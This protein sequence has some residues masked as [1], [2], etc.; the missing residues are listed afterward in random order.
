MSSDRDDQ[1]RALGAFIRLQ[2]NLA[3]LSLRQMADLAEVSN[4]YLSQI[5]RGLHEPS[6]SV[7]RSI[8]RALN[9]SAEAL[10][11]QVGLFTDEEG[12]GAGAGTSGTEAAIS[13]DGRLNH[14]QKQALLNVYRTYVASNEPPAGAPNEAQAGAS[15][16]RRR[17][18][19]GR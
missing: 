5:E 16:E 10:L 14:D 3:N 8:A 2:R 1:L 7:I 11:G 9:L 17:P 4:P 6:V 13:S 12:A 18:S 15:N 19:D